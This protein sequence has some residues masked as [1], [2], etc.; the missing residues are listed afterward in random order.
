MQAKTRGKDGSAG[1]T[2]LVSAPRAQ[3]AL[4]RADARH[5]S[6]GRIQICRADYLWLGARG[7]RPA[8]AQADVYAGGLG[9]IYVES[10]ADVLEEQRSRRGA[11]TGGVRRFGDALSWGR[12]RLPAVPPDAATNGL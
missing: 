8:G 9:S 5:Y 3:S 10:S 11:G 1:R 6:R 2:F 7:R 4:V 12:A